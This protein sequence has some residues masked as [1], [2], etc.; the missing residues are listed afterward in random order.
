MC[1]WPKSAHFLSNSSSLSIDPAIVNFDISTE[2]NITT[3]QFDIRE[4]ITILTADFR[5]S[6]AE[7]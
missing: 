7:L 4:S 5:R 6:P 2:L 1:M 3:P